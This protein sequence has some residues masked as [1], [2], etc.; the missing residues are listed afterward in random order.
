[1]SLVRYREYPIIGLLIIGDSDY[2]LQI[3]ELQKRRFPRFWGFG[4]AENRLFYILFELTKLRWAKIDKGFLFLFFFIFSFFHYFRQR[5]GNSWPK[6]QI[7]YG[8]GL[9]LPEPIS[10]VIVR[11]HRKEDI[12]FK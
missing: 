8:N 2:A 9:N 10:L 11:R 12:S 1:M 4:Y 7:E 6:I 3:S 5:V